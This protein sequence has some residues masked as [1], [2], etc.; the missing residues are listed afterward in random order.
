MIIILRKSR[1]N[2]CGKN[3]GRMPACTTGMV[4]FFRKGH[5][6]IKT[7]ERKKETKAQLLPNN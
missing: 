2:Q 1:E 6:Y 5:I 7:L 4:A 3:Q